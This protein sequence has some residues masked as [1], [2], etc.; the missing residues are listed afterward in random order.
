[1]KTVHEDYKW[2]QWMMNIYRNSKWGLYMRT[3]HES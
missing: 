3:V 2:K 1:M